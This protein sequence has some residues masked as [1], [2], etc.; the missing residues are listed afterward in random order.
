[1]ATDDHQEEEELQTFTVGGNNLTP[2][3]RIGTLSKAKSSFTQP[4]SIF[5]ITSSLRTGRGWFL[6]QALAT[7]GML[8]S[9]HYHSR[10]LHSSSKWS[11]RCSF[12]LPTHQRFPLRTLPAG[13]VTAMQNLVGNDANS[14]S[15][16]SAQIA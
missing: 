9:E 2:Q 4:Y 11:Q 16:L 7:P 8:Y 5:Y 3:V 1:M 6:S 14:T 15:Q 13:K 10:S 12:R